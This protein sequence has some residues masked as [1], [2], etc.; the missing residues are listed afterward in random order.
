MWEYFTLKRAWEKKILAD[1]AQEKQEGI[2]GQWQQESP[3]KEVLE[4]AKR[5]ADTDCNAQIMCRA[6][7]AKKSGNWE[8]FT[9]ELRDNCK[10]C[11]PALQ[12]LPFG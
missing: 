12:L 1:A 10:L 7:N 4:Q 3:F 5:N 6:Y 9:E 11:L 2:Q 8:S